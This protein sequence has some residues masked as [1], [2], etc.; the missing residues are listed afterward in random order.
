MAWAEDCLIGDARHQ[1]EWISLLAYGPPKTAWFRVGIRM[2]PL[3]LNDAEP[4]HPTGITPYIFRFISYYIHK[5]NLK[6]VM[7][8]YISNRWKSLTDSIIKLF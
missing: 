6:L 1:V 7:E 3:T 8:M 2:R 4:A 5:Q